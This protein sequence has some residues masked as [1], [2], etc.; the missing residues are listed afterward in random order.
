MVQA[1]QTPVIFTPV[2]ASVSCSV[3]WDINP[4]QV[5]EMECSKHKVVVDL[6]LNLKLLPSC[7]NDLYKVQADSSPSWSSVS[8]HAD[9]GG[10][11]ILCCII[12]SILHFSQGKT[13][14]A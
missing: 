5:Q 1:A 2:S 6:L 10:E 4:H 13:L 3:L 9:K 11:P 7:L 8:V 14:A 12:T